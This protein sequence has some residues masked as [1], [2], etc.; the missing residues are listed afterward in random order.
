MRTYRIALGLCAGAAL[1]AAAA[2]AGDAPA[3]RP[4]YADLRYEED[5]SALA[6]GEAASGD[7]F[8]PI[9]YVP[10]TES[11]SAWLSF[12]A[13][14]RERLELWDDF[15]FGDPPGSDPDDV[16]LLSRLLVHADLHLAPWLRVFAQG[17]SALVTDRDLVGGARPSD[18]DELDLQNGFLELESPEWSGLGAH[19]ARRAPG[20]LVR[21]AAPREPARLGE[22]AADV[23]RRL[24][25][26]ELPDAGRRPDSWRT[27]SS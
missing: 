17:K 27:P 7:L 8:D 3:S 25:R 16:F 14:L 23:R 15:R 21:R 19:A 12:G 11:G 1:L 9:K 2:R 26:A 13:Q 20:A 5:W 6:R 4:R 24:G 10:L 22:R 18:A